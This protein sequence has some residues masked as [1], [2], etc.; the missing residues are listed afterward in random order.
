[1]S[2]LSG[3]SRRVRVGIAGMM[4]LLG[5]IGADIGVAAQS[6]DAVILGRVTDESGAVLPGVTVTAASPAL[7]IGQMSDTTNASGEYRLAPLP[8]GTYT[9]EY[10]LPG[11]QTLRRPDVRLTA[12]F[13]AQ[14]DEVLKLGAVAETIT[15]SGAAPVIDTR[16][17]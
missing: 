14:I 1:M 15:V 5:L 2:E 12:G 10:S 17:T 3:R 13:T 7:Q 9:I 8:I 6:L 4:V 11:F 16:S